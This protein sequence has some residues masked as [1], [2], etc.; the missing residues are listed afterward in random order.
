MVLQVYLRG[1]GKVTEFSKN[2]FPEGLWLA[3]TPAP[4]MAKPPDEMIFIRRFG[5]MRFQFQRL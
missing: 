3:G 4:P 5:L 1:G 2:Y